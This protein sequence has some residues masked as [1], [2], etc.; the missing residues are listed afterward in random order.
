M[1]RPPPS[2]GRKPLEQRLL[3]VIALQN[4]IAAAQNNLDEVLS[5]VVARAPELTGADAGVVE[6]REGDEMVYR[7]VSGTAT[8]FLGLRLHVDE[9]LS[10]LAVK[11]GRVMRCDDAATDPRV[12][13]LAAEAVGAISMLCVPLEDAAAVL[14]VLKLYAEREGA[15]DADD[16]RLAGLL[17]QVIGT[18]LG[19][20][21]PSGLGGRPAY[22]ARLA[23]EVA[24]AARYDRPLSVARFAFDPEAAGPDETERIKRAIAAVRGGDEAFQLGPGEFAV[25]LPETDETGAE[26]M[27]TRVAGAA[28]AV[29]VAWGVAERAGG[30]PRDLH[31][32][33]A[34]LHR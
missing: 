14:G 17:S 25:L 21:A 2:T 16:E 15:F 19:R 28:G 4:A 1:S 5:I 7:A 34:A 22:D 13:R 8:P 30:G 24:R 3:E 12:D 29:P 31:A 27:A 32:R 6:F 18:H 33:A 26:R 9:S 20:A 23:K 10:G 11:E